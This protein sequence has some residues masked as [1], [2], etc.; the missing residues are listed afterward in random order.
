MRCMASS[1]DVYLIPKLSTP[2]VN[3]V[4]LKKCFQSP[5]M[6]AHSM[7][8]C[9]DSHVFSNLLASISACGKLYILDYFEVKIVIRDD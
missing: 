4:S 8:L 9:G 3:I 1:V 6:C 7:Y 2:W 5:G